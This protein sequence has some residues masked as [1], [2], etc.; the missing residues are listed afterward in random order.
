MVVV[1]SEFPLELLLEV[2]KMRGCWIGVLGSAILAGTCLRLSA[3]DIPVLTVC[4]ALSNPQG[5]DG[6]LV[7]IVG[8]LTS[9][10]EGGWL[11]EECGQKFAAAGREFGSQI[12]TAYVVSDFAAAPT[13]PKGFK[14]DKR[15]LT[16]KLNLVQ[17]TTKLRVYERTKTSDEWLAMFGRLETKLPRQIDLGNGRT[18]YTTGFGHMSAS[19]A[20][21]ISPEGGFVRLHGSPAKPR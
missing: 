4:E 8:R 9:T 2:P 14:W 19:P 7:I 18:G 13:L 16:E 21:L 15:L 12:S 1:Q 5:F 20:Q 10:G 3:E 6:K 17:R 11:D